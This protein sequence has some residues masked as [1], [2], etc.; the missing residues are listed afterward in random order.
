MVNVELLI[1]HAPPSEVE[2]LP[3]G[4]VLCTGVEAIVTLRPE[5]VLL[6]ILSVVEIGET[7]CD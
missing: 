1:R 6:D 7:T 2:L 3:R 5:E 4:D